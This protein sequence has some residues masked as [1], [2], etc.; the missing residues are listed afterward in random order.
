MRLLA[1]LSG[2]CSDSLRLQRMNIICQQSCRLCLK[3]SPLQESHFLPAA[4]YRQMM[5]PGQRNAN[6]V[7][8]TPK[9][10]IQSSHQMKKPLLCS[11]CEDRFNRNGETWVLGVCPRRN[12]RFPLRELLQKAS[13]IWPKKTLLVYAGRDIHGLK[14]EQLVYFAASVF[15]RASVSSWTSMGVTVNVDLG[16]RYQEEFRQYLLGT[17]PFPSNATMWVTV[18]PAPNPLPVTFAPCRVGTS[19]GYFHFTLPIP[20]IVFDLFVGGSIPPLIRRT[21][22]LRSNEGFIFLT[23]INDAPLLD[24]VVKRFGKSRPIGGLAGGN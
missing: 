9:I 1:S 20:G 2:Y 24:A 17:A 13:P 22:A 15:W 10:A 19:T 7:I 23:N 16:S 12:G 8:M 18:S 3:R 6:P 5:E 4:L 14:L 11:V 21:C